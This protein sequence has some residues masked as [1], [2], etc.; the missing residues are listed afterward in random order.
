VDLWGRLSNPVET[1]EKLADQGWSGRKRQP[2]GDRGTPERANSGV[3]A[4]SSEQEG[5]HSNPVQRRLS[6]ADISE[7]CGLY[8]EG[9]SIDGLARRYEVNRTTI[10]TH[11][12]RAGIARR[13]VARKMT[14]DSVSRA[15]SRYGEGLSLAS[16][17]Q[18]FGVHG[19]TLAREFRQAG[20]SIRPRRGC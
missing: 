10:I 8:G 1:L 17:A 5:R 2:G 3:S 6:A 13:R 20:M 4:A 15:A 11:L 7:L 14:D 16:V 19:R 12:D 18:E 9:A